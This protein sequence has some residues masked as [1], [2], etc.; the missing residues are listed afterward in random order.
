M[1]QF[2]KA[3]SGATLGMSLTGLLASIW[4]FQQAGAAAVQIHPR[5]V[6]LAPKAAPSP[7]R[8]AQATPSLRS[9]DARLQEL[10]LQAETQEAKGDYKQALKLRQQIFLITEEQRGPGHAETA[11]SLNNLAAVYYSLGRHKEAE[12]LFKQSLSIREKVLGVEHPETA[13]TLSN[14]AAVYANLDRRKEAEFL[15]KRALAI[16]KKALGSDHPDTATSLNNL[17]ALYDDQG[18]YGDAEQ[19]YKRAL[20]IREKVLGAEHPSTATTLNNLAL[21][22]K[23]QGRYGEAEP[24]YRRS[25]AIRQKVLG[26]AHPVTAS[27]LIN[28]ARLHDKQG[29]VNEAEAL[30]KRA[31]AIKEDI[32]GKEHLETAISLNNLAVLYRSQSRYDEA[33]KL[34]KRSLAIREKILGSGHSDTAT[35][36]A[37]LGALYVDQGRYAE[38]QPL[39]SKA[40]LIREAVLGRENLAAAN[41]LDTLAILFGRQNRYRDAELTHRRSIDIKTKLLGLEHPSTATSLNNLARL[42]LRQGNLQDAKQLLES[43]NPAQA[44]WLRRELIVQPRDLRL[45]LSKNQTDTLTTTFALLHQSSDAAPLAIEAR[46]NRQGLM[47]EIERRQALLRASSLE[48]RRLAEQVAKL[49]RH[50]ASLTLRADQREPLRQQRQRLEAELYRLYPALKIDPVST[51]EVAAALRT[52]APQGVLVEFQKYKPSITDDQAQA[53]DVPEHYVALM[54]KPDGRISAVKLGEAAA[55]D[56]AVNIALYAI[57]KNEL[58]H[59]QALS[60]LS[61]LLIMPLQSHLSGVDQLFLSPDG[62]LNRVPFTALPNPVEPARYLSE[63]FQ[64]RI[65][66]TGRDLVRLRQ[67]IKTTLPHSTA[68]NVLMADPDFG[69]IRRASNGAE[70]PLWPPLPYTKTE[71]EELQALLRVQQPFTGK[72]ATTARLLRL[73]SPRV[74]HIATHGFFQPELSSPGL[75]TGTGEN[76]RHLQPRPRHDATAKDPM[77]RIYLALAGANLPKATPSDDGRLTAAEATGMDLEGTELVTLSACETARGQ[78]RS[79]EGVYGLQRALTVAGARSTLLSLWRVND[80]RTAVFMKEFYSQLKKGKPR[81]EALR[82]TQALFRNHHNPIYRDVYAWGGFQLTGDWRPV[83]GL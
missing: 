78:I 2:A 34:Y 25:L 57:T 65:L 12:P 31:I 1:R 68:S 63:A 41:S 74:V 40:L 30:Y 51:T 75:N 47:A 79:G 58:R 3:A 10:T 27:S 45:T 28:L 80:E 50:L 37:N 5:T 19:L 70:D 55:I 54:L 52:S 36:L 21:L 23:N 44:N 8:L 11:T 22:Y 69:P 49:D 43:L 56:E 83:E 76:N 16:R 66:T 61:Q 26:L 13:D 42:Q 81:A 60:N 14:L 46:L 39:L 17:A 59:R 20:A 72:G 71:A 9:A 32:L 4:W 35:N 77:E 64:L 7:W 62:E 53:S 82:A 48:I 6:S 24:L 18:L 15:Y 33:E 73:R 29:R 38:A 67:P